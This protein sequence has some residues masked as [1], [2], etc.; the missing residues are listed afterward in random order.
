M[1]CGNSLQT[2]KERKTAPTQDQMIA[3]GRTTQPMPQV[4]PTK[5]YRVTGY[6]TETTIDST[7]EL[8]PQNISSL[9]ASAEERRVVTVM[10]ADITGS[11]PLADRLDPEDMRAILNGY[12]NLMTEQIRKYDGTVE[13][14]IGDAVMAVF[15]TPVTHEDD[16]ERAIR[17][18][19]DM[20]NALTAFNL[21][22]LARDPQVTRLQMRIGINTGEVAAPVNTA[23]QHQDFLVT[24]DAVNIAARLQQN[25]VPDAILVGERTYLA[26]RDAFDFTDMASLAL[27]GK[28]EPIKAYTVQSLHQQTTTISRH[29]RG[30]SGYR[31]PLIGRDLELTLLFA[32]YARVQAEHSPHL[33][34][35]L[36]APGIGK[37]RL[38]REFINR[39]QELAKNS[40][41]YKKQAPPLILKGR[42]PPYGEGITYWPLVEILRTLLHVQ[43]TDTSQEL[44]QRLVDFLRDTFAKAQSSESA[45]EVADILL[46]RIGRGLISTPEPLAD[47]NSD[48]LSILSTERAK[49]EITTTSRSGELKQSGAQGALLRVWRVL[50]EALG[51]VQPVIIVIDD[52]QWA[53]EALLDLLEYLTDRITAVPVL[54]LC[55]ARPDFLEYRRNWGGGHRNFTAIELDALT[56]E[57]SNDL[58]DSLLNTHDFPEA[59]RYSILLRSEGNPFFVEEIV[60]M[61]IDQGILVHEQAS[62]SGQDYWRVE[63]P[64]HAMF[65]EP[66][67]HAHSEQSEIGPDSVM[68][69]HFVLPIP[70][71][72]DTI[73][74]VL[75]AR[76][77]LLEPVE[78]VILQYGAIVGRNFWL[79][80]L[81]E[82]CADLSPE[83]ILDGLVSLIRRDFITENSAKSNSPIVN[84]HS[85]NFKHILIR[86]V[87]Y[88][89]IPRLRRAR[90]H[91]RIAL[92]IGQ[93]AQQQSAELIELIAY[94][95]QQALTTWSV[96]A[97]ME[98]IELPSTQHAHNT[99][100]RLTRDML[101]QQAI[102]YL[103]LTGDQALHGY[104]GLRALRAYND[105]Y[106]L[107]IDG[108]TD[109][110]ERSRMLT[111]IADAQALRGNLDEAWQHNRL[112]LQIATEEGHEPDR[113]YLLSIYEHLSSM[114]TRW[115]PRFDSPP[116]PQEIRNYINAGLQLLAGTPTSR[117]YIAFL[118]Y[119]AFWYIRQ[120]DDAPSTKK[121][122]LVEHALES[123][124]RA[125]S[126]A[127]ELDNPRTLSLTIDAMG[128]IYLVYHRYTRARELQDR[129]LGLVH[130]LTDKEELYDLYVSLG[131]AHEHVADYA[132]ALSHYGQAYSYAMS[133]ESPA[134]VLNA[135][136]GRMRVWR[137]WNRWDETQKVAQEILQ[138][139][140]KYQQDE[141]RQQWAIEALATIAYHRGQQEQGDEYARQLKR[142]TD[143]QMAAS[144]T[145]AG[146]NTKMHAIYL[147]Q[148]N[149]S[150]ALSDYQEKVNRSEPFPDPDEL[151]TLAEL[152]VTT[153]QTEGVEEIC[154]RAVHHSE[155]SGAHKSHAVALRARGRLF[156]SRQLWEQA[157]AD[158]RASLSLCEKLGLPWENAH[159]H[160]HLGL[161]YTYRA[162]Q[163]AESRT[164]E[165]DLSMAHNYLER[166]LGFYESLQAL[167]AMKRTRAALRESITIG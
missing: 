66:T 163:P 136:I 149:W 20:Q 92:W 153:E 103:T 24:G 158:L 161:F 34:T 50:L 75:A 44:Q 36:G 76:V 104:Y 45:E 71:V 142:L 123:G 118:T 27:K 98:Y 79:S 41:A 59:L 4:V 67:T 54:F 162:E 159:I 28:P 86:D 61:L 105:A 16:P 5:D 117:E 68:N 6:Q 137:R 121:A 63:Y 81:I 64:R 135:I 154:N 17:A 96:S 130:L 166:A 11:T 144:K 48:A 116:E 141:K 97:S 148:E 9:L 80:L 69:S 25:T 47:A 19:L 106:D 60:R 1:E 132:T 10:F 164:R 108:Q 32:S 43:T 143:Q 122:D 40:S 91:A 65:E 31:T 140:D 150:R 72:P 83:T 26:T 113:T 100:I 30:I 87:V 147:A 110:L 126:M 125:L 84:D 56:E 42:C 128:F 165:N 94:H 58:V 109:P 73:Q 127:E 152:M 151:A 57:E 70:Y 99:L 88:N 13:K 102:K 62:E 55:P 112:A 160:Y 14:Y 93:H 101:R 156:A 139:I 74:G 129:R 37:T 85:Y 145:P 120:L 95:Y 114:A 157:E 23:T 22:R 107:L 8:A 7:L 90:E 29:L 18:A 82:Q 77:D 133:M 53:D 119:E 39:E 15:G 89:N 49:P 38:V 115:R 138:F 46:R 131:G 111:K 51:K 146:I 12:F 52:L 124:H 3:M 134:M 78:K 21:Q 167:P 33:I 2:A 155:S 35:L